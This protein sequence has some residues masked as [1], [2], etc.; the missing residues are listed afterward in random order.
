MNLQV[1]D[2]V[3]YLNTQQPIHFILLETGEDFVT[4]ISDFNEYGEMYVT[5]IY[6]YENQLYIELKSE[7]L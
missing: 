3:K 2:I 1:K 5:D 7:I 4:K 6:V